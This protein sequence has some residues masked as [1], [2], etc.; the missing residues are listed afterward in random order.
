M[1]AIARLHE[2]I[3]YKGS[4]PTR[5]EKE[6]GLSNGYLGTQLKRNADLGESI[7][8]KIIDYCL[9][10]NP[11]WLLTG[12]L[13]MLRSVDNQNVI[14]QI[15]KPTKYTEKTIEMQ[16][17]PLYDISAAANLKTLFSQKNQNILGNIKLPN[18]TR[19]DG[20]MYV[21]GDSMEP[22]IK[23]G[24]LICYKEINDLTNIVYGN[25]YLVSMDVEGEEYLTLKYI[26]RSDF[27]KDWI[28][29][30]SHNKLHS[31][32]DFELKRINAI[33]LVKIS[34]RMNTM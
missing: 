11:E 4:K 2:Y 34:I 9:D 32:K 27:G 26:V 22:V 15:H 33:A 10:I 16:E 18:M 23:A 24:D 25:I 13:P 8:N 17:I 30:E 1:K 14:T 21:V 19:C 28:R 7:I 12:K 29:L 6:L 20:A 5:F 31:P 3:D